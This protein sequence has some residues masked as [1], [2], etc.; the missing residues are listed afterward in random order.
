VHSRDPAEQR[1]RLSILSLLTASSLSLVGSQLTAVALPWFVLKATGSPFTTGIVA[2][3]VFLSRF[4]VGFV[5]GPM[6]DRLGYKRAGVWTDVLSAAG[7]ALLP[8]LYH[9][10][11]FVLWELVLAVALAAAP[12]IPGLT[13]RRS[14]LPELARSS[15]LRLERV[16]G[17]YESVQQLSLLLGAPI[18]GALIAGFGAVN[19]FWIDAFTFGASAAL[20]AA[21]VPATD[22]GA[23]AVRVGRYLADLSSG[24]RFL[25]LDG[26][27]RTL[28]GGVA[29]SNLIGAGGIAIIYP[30]YARRVLDDP[31]SLGL[32]VGALGGGSLVGS[33]LYGALGHRLPRRATVI[34]ALSTLPLAYWLFWLRPPFLIVV[35]VLVLV[36]LAGGVLNPL[37]VTVRQ[38]RIPK[39]LR[40][41]V[42]SSFSAVVG[43]TPALGALL[44]GLLVTRWGLSV[45][46]LTL[47]LA[48]Q[49]LG[50]LLLLAPDLRE[51]DRPRPSS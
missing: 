8:V 16:N 5:G 1:A 37:G 11:G 12:D 50:L 42:F 28:A 19:V 44:T 24:F 9:A 23:I 49:L 3:A 17:A 27:L 26:P 30:V 43:S 10:F 21:F 45:G 22:G 25:A 35:L 7:I 31:F 46:T 33:L 48:G 34:V 14:L 29:L 32:M 6:V 39:D 13:A 4:V 15:G 47:A 36:G 51:L 41:R 38:E 20:I 2:S 40:G 18:G